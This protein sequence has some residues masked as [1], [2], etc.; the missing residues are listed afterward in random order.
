MNEPSLFSTSSPRSTPPP[1]TTSTFA[2]VKPAGRAM[3]PDRAVS[4]SSSNEALGGAVGVIATV[5]SVVPSK[6]AVSRKPSRWSATSISSV[7]MPLIRNPSTAMAMVKASALVAPGVSC[8][9]SAGLRIRSGWNGPTGE[10]DNRSSVAASPLERL[11]ALAPFRRIEIL[12]CNSVPEN[13]F[14]SS[15]AIT[16]SRMWAKVCS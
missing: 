13:S 12:S 7:L 4:S 6:R 1:V 5:P 10:A 2:G 9:S 8:A 3:S 16:R 15:D 14:S 11:I